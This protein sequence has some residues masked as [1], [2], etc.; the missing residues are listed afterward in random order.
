[1]ELPEGFNSS[2]EGCIALGV[3]IGSPAY[4]RATAKEKLEKMAPPTGSLPLL[5][6]RSG[7]LL[8]GK[9][10][11]PRATY[12]LRAVH[13]LGNI[14]DETK[15][16]DLRFIE[17]IAGILKLQV[18]QEL[19]TRI[20]LP[21]SL[22]GLGHSPH[23]GMASE[24]NQIASR[25]HYINYLSIYHPTK[26]EITLE[27]YDQ[28]Q[29]IM[30][31]LED[32]EELTEISQEDRES[33]D[34]RTCKGLL[35]TGKKLA[36]TVISDRLYHDLRLEEDK[37]RAASFLSS[38]NG[39]T[40]FLD[41]AVGMDRYF[42]EQT[43]ICAARMRLGAG[44][45]DEPPGAI[46]VCGCGLAYS[47]GTNPFHGIS[48][49]LNGNFRT[50]CHT[51]IIALLYALI[52]KQCPNAA[53]GKEKEVGRMAVGPNGHAPAVRADIVAAIGP[54]TY[55]IDVSTTDPC[56]RVSLDLNPS[57]ADS[58]GA[59]AKERE[60]TKRNHYRKVV[61]PLPIPDGNVVPFVIETTG[62]LGPG[63][64]SFLLTVCPTQ[65]FIRS[66][67]LNAVVMIVSK[68]NGKCLLA[69]RDRFRH[70]L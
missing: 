36:D 60:R 66:R 7:T 6:A 15:A 32:R 59:A 19:K 51:E 13:D 50:F 34:F 9:C 8:L 40:A 23:H 21:R 67:F 42:G 28:I 48:C 68:Y 57:S 64:M 41:S 17:A 58:V 49:R 61:T 63:A 4:C 39:G 3:P 25:L 69:T 55:V 70:N 30:G 43:F 20:G 2:P 31:A 54:I 44:P 38:S 14:A 47:A 35:K 22:G 12:M 18:T 37:S 65:T 5:K 56:C 29:V 26:T 62:R 10:Y 52:R 46:R 27:Q 24:A 45:S 16:Y 33:M 53:T 11:A 1:M